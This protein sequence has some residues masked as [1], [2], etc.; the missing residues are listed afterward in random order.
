MAQEVP[1]PTPINVEASAEISKGS[2]NLQGPVSRF[3]VSLPPGGSHNPRPA[4]VENGT[5][6]EFALNRVDPGGA[7]LRTE[8]EDGTE[9]EVVEDDQGDQ[10][11]QL[12]DANGEIVGGILIEATR[13]S[14]GQPVRSELA[15]EGKTITPKFLAGNDEIKEPV[16]VDVY[17]ST[18]WYNK[19]WVTK[20]SGKK[21][22]VNLDPTR[23]GRKQN[24]LNTHK[25]HVKH[26]KKVL[27]STNTKK[28]WNYNIEQQFLC[29]VVGA[30]FPTG[31][32]NMESW[33]PTKK[34]QQIANPFDRC[35][36]K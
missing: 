33:R 15:V 29:H 20:K 35:N 3:N 22:V 25:T 31:V 28:H 27:G 10:S 9:I 26:A 13:S 21:Y 12:T 2:L 14:N 24:A 32:Y 5:G 8:V 30:W 23:L 7:A 34:W 6:A 19:G 17:A 4:V 11:I 36:R 16:S 1:E 18:V